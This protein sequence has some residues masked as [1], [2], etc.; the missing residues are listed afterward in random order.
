MGTCCL[1]G[2]S[3][4]HVKNVLRRGSIARSSSASVGYG[5]AETSVADQPAVRARSLAAADLQSV[6]AYASY[7]RR[8]QGTRRWSD[9]GGAIWPRVDVVGARHCAFSFLTTR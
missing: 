9:I 5:L 8:H 3:T 6:G 1:D 4:D 7:I 2:S